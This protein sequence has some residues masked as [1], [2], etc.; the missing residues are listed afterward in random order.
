[1]ST[2]WIGLVVGA[3]AVAV[4]MVFATIAIVAR[5]RGSITLGL[6]LTVGWWRDLALGF[7]IG[8]AAFI[9][10]SI[11]SSA[12]R[13][14][15][16]E[17]IDPDLATVAGGVAVLFVLAVYEELLFRVLLISGLLVATRSAAVSVVITIA[18]T[19]INH[20]FTEGVTVLSMVSA[21]LGGVMYTAAYL[22]TGRWWLPLGMHLAW[23]IVQGPLLGYPVSG[24]VIGPGP[25]IDQQSSGPNWLTGGAYGPEASVTAIAARLV[26][27]ILLFVMAT[28]HRRRSGSAPTL[29][30]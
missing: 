27:I 19:A 10:I 15:T 13:V 26:I 11:A 21:T 18:V 23:N 22:I 6:R 14:S 16:V 7:G 20:L 1:M 2:G 12:M 25:V 29:S 28:R 8:S 24:T 4:A 5:H 30:R 3:S 9:A 17:R